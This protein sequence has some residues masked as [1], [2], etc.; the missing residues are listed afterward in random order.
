MGKLFHERFL[1]PGIEMESYLSWQA[2]E[3]IE[4]K[5]REQETQISGAEPIFLR[6]CVVLPHA[7]NDTDRRGG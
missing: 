2:V 6:S 5:I 4:N 7:R 3:D 1:P